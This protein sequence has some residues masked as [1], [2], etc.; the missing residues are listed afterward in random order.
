M[1]NEYRSVSYHFQ[2]YYNALSEAVTIAKAKYP[3]LVP[4]GWKINFITREEY[5]AKAKPDIVKLNAKLR[6]LEQ[7]KKWKKDAKKKPK[8][9]R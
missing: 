2:S 3:D 8:R 1:N 6:F 9:N 7:R 4:S 5:V